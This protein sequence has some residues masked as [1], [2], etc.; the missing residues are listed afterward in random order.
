[1]TGNAIQT[2]TFILAWGWR[3]FTGYYLPGTNVTP[4][5]LCLFI[6]LTR[7]VISFFGRLYNVQSNSNASSRKHYNTES[8]N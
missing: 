1:M 5:A 8:D 3:F 4:G 6:L 2:L 7:L